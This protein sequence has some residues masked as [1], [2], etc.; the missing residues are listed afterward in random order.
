MAVIQKAIKTIKYRYAH[1][2]TDD[3]LRYA[4]F[5]KLPKQS[6]FV[7][8]PLHPARRRLRGFNQAEIIARLLSK[9]FNIP[10]QTDI[11]KRIRK[12]VPQV[13]MKNRE[14]RLFN[15]KGVFIV[16]EEVIPSIQQNTIILV[17][18]VYTTGATM[19]SACEALKRAG[20]RTV[21]GLT[22]AQ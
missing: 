5:S 18:D 10:V 8:I 16:N 22:I 6:L 20:V 11:L 15:M 17:D 12:T 3:L 2:V 9:R 13:D 7:P 19:Q 1:K 4:S 14:N 21:W